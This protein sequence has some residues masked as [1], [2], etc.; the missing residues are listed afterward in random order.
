M[1]AYC[2]RYSTLYCKSKIWGWWEIA[3]ILIYRRFVLLHITGFL[4]FADLNKTL[5]VYTN[6]ESNIHDTCQLANKQ[7]HNCFLKQF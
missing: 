5:A 3:N 4:S 7:I 2:D 6:G 1:L